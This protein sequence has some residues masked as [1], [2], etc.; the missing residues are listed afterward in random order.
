MHGV[1][2]GL[3][4]SMEADTWLRW[5]PELPGDRVRSL[6]VAAVLVTGEE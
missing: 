6:A 4:I 2:F 3:E 5:A 1:P